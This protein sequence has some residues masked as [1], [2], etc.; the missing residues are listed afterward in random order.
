MTCFIS[1]YV[2]HSRK[3][4]WRPVQLLGEPESQR[5]YAPKGKTA[6]LNCLS[7]TIFICDF[8]P[9]IKW[10]K[11]LTFKVC[12]CVKILHMSYM[13]NTSGSIQL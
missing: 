6:V 12:F 4:Q 7:L 8:I 10:K 3:H 5:F 1:F 2:V 9:S 11:F 13:K